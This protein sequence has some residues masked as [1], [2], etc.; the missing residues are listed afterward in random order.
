MAKRKNTT[1]T[2]PRPAEVEIVEIASEV[3]DSTP[4]TISVTSKCAGVVYIAGNKIVPNETVSIDS[5]HSAEL[6]KF[7]KQGLIKINN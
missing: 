4:P 1:T 6:E 7:R 2:D 3:D 5:A